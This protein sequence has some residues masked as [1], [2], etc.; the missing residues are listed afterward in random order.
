MSATRPQQV[1]AAD[2]ALDESTWDRRSR[3]RSPS[4]RWI[5]W[6]LRA[7]VVAALFG[8]LAVFVLMRALS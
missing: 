2:T 4:A 8:C 3:N 6:R 7:L 1:G 5:G